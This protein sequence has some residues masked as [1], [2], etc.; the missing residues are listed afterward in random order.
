MCVTVHSAAYKSLY[1]SAE[2][3]LNSGRTLDEWMS[4]RM[5]EKL[6]K[7]LERPKEEVNCRAESMQ[8]K[9]CLIL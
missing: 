4:G 5:R 1:S 8:R 9:R 6:Y 3:P 2:E 7:W